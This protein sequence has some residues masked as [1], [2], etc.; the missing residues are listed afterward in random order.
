MV[1][2]A[3]VLFVLM[4]IIVLMVGNRFTRSIKQEAQ[5][6]GL[7]VAQSIAAVSTN[8]LLTYNYVSLAQN[9]EQASQGTD[10]VY[11]IVLDKEEKVAAFSGHSGWEGKYL[12]DPVN[13]KALA[14]ERPVIQ[15]VFW[16]ETGERVLDI[17][18]PVFIS[19]SD[20]KGGT[21]RVGLS[22]E[23]MYWQ[24]R[25]TQLVLVGIGT[26]ALI[27]GLAGA[28][29][30]A[31]RITQPLGQLA[32]ATVAAAQGDLDHRLDIHTRD[33]VEDLANS[34]NTMIREIL[35]QRV[36]LEQRLDEIL[37]LKAY[38]DIVLASMTNGLLTLDLGSRIVSA[39]DAA[40]CILGLEGKHWQGRRFADLWLEDNSFVRLL[41]KCL[42]S[43]TPCL[44]QEILLST[45]G[46]KQST[47]MVNTS[48]LEDGKGERLGVVVVIND[49][50]EVKALEARMRQSDRLAALGTLSAGLAH[51]IRNPLSAIK[52]FVQ[53]LPRKMSNPAFLDK[54][55]TTVPRELNRIN[56]LIESLLELARP[57]KLEFE[58][59][60]LSECLSQV[61]D[62]YRDKLEA[63]NIT[64]EISQEQSL[65]EL[66]ADKEHLVR[67]LS[68]IVINALEAMPEGGHLTVT[69]EELAGG[70]V[71]QFTDT[72]AGMD[73]AAQDKIFNPFFTTKDTGTGLGLALTHKIIQE[74]G[75]HI[76]VESVTGK[77]T[78]FTLT[79]PRVQ[80]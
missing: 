39:N 53:L 55:Q 62:V 47:L 29:V 49:I 2:T 9:A 13:K 46:E 72:G 73:E 74:H 59:A 79:F 10:I 15:S 5:A 75:G 65:P 44:N 43:Q 76:E 71:L 1:A 35:D 78:T 30:M 17:G 57:P 22:L 68:N 69:A 58:M 28:H 16:Q 7:A 56:G 25:R 61:E 40:G 20:R 19:G 54:F 33:E 50:T 42:E 48:F 70:V 21:V 45:G 51:E 14:A 24:I 36:Q 32:N 18:V 41:E 67:A 63:S 80:A 27:L 12:D 26:V 6:R 52:T 23:R 31:S 34:F 4:V 11:V 37:E 38:N 64:L 3:A 77:G 8:A 66:W 60:S